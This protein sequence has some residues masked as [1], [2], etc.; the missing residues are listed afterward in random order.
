VRDYGELPTVWG[1]ATR[2]GQLLL[3]LLL[4]VARGL[5]EGDGDRNQVWVIARAV[6]GG[7][8]I[9]LRDNVP[10]PPTVAPA[11]FDVVAMCQ[12]IASALG[13]KVSAGLAPG[14]GSSFVLF[15]PVV[16][17]ASSRPRDVT[18]P[19]GVRARPRLLIV[20][21]EPAL[22]RALSQELE[23][24]HQ[25]TTVTSGRA[26]L[27]LLGRTSFDVILC[28]LMMPE[29]S[30]MDLYAELRRAGDG[31][32][33]RMVFMTGGAF[34]ESARGFL[35]ATS[36]P[37]VEKPFRMEALRQVLGRQRRRASQRAQHHPHKRV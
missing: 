24:D 8:E 11:G 18:P 31:V 23:R 13:G 14:G 5:P 3:N 26:A 15:L 7:L 9:T 32:E 28:D 16:E 19:Q 25:V 10:K 17:A 4:H 37:C 30:G 2:L 1:Q 12:G 29:M 35:E 33:E 21:D 20:D 34:T 22:L 36:N 27:E 6:A